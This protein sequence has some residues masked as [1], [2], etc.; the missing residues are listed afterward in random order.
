MYVNVH[1][2]GILR[3]KDH[4]GSWHPTIDVDADVHRVLAAPGRVLAACA[5]G[6]AVSED[7]GDTWT[8]RTDGLHATYCRGV[9]RSGSTVLVSASD[10]PRG[11]RAAL[12]RGAVAGGPFERC[13]QG[14]PEWFSGNVDSPCLDAAPDAGLAAFGTADG[15]VF[16]S[17]DEGVTWSDVAGGLP[18]PHCVLV[19]P[20]GGGVPG[21]DGLEC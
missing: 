4:G 2:G 11:G 3:S 15:R 10:G 19:I 21:R 20:R 5:R 18:A 12:Y 1:V 6:L 7:G 14:L 9:A 8:T 17:T 13:V 16:A